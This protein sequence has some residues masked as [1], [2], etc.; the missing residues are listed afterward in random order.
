M[1]AEILDG[2]ILAW[3]VFTWI[4]EGHHRRCTVISKCPKCGNEK[5]VHCASGEE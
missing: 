1:L 3:L 2:L 4:Y 5:D